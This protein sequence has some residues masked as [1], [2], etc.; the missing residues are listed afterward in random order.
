M[1]RHIRMGVIKMDKR[2]ITELETSI[3]R[4][5][6]V[7][8]ELT[9]KVE[10]L[11]KLQIQTRATI[12]SPIA[13]PR[14]TGM[15]TEKVSPWLAQTAIGWD[16]L[17]KRISQDIQSS[18]ASYGRTYKALLKV[19]K[20]LTASEVGK[21]T[22][23]DRNTESAHLRRLFLMG[24]LERVPEGKKVKY[25]INKELKGEVRAVFGFKG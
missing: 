5:Q 21:I 23:R 20:P 2:R 3:T 15:E 8:A 25:K 11:N 16:A 10:A 1:S 19:R 13:A 24:Y 18:L 9:T 14:V 22:Y 4:L 6:K 17:Y 7:V 12:A